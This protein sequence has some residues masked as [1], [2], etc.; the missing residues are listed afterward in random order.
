MASI[1]GGSI[2]MLSH[3][4][5]CMMPNNFFEKSLLD[6]DHKDWKRKKDEETKKKKHRRHP[7]T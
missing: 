3:N 7:K 4:E 1:K 6:A 2:R 5:K